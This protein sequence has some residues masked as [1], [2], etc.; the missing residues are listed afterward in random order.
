MSLKIFQINPHG[1]K[2]KKKKKFESQNI[3]KIKKVTSQ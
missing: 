1:R 2:K 3:C